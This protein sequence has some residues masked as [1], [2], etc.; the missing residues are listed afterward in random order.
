MA[1]D[2]LNDRVEFPGR[3][4]EPSDDNETKE[5][6]AT[7][8]RDKA[9]EYAFPDSLTVYDV[10]SRAGIEEMQ[11]PLSSLWWSGLAA[12][13]CISISL[14]MMAALRVALEG[15]PGAAAL[16]KFGYCFGFLI[17]VLGRL[18]LFTENTI[19]PVLPAMHE[20][21]LEAVKCVARLWSVVFVANLF[22]TFLSASLPL[23]FPIA[24]DEIGKAVLDISLHFAERTPL[25]SFF[26]AIPAG[27]LVA[28]M[29][30]ML[31]SSNGFE[32]WTI[33]AMTYAIAVADTSHVIVGSTELFT[34][35]LHGKMSVIDA[36]AQLFLTGLGNIL[37]GTGLFALLAYAQVKQEI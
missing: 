13:I 17:V 31:P 7:D 16:E 25:E 22:G 24:S 14:F 29:V 1:A 32:F 36:V 18:Q 21:S 11:R 8:R 34:V 9:E 2:K 37:G 6:R 26:T 5:Q 3:I 10:V 35:M 4:N 30:W 27:F 33:I 20:R 12:G 23:L 19:T 15:V 28:A